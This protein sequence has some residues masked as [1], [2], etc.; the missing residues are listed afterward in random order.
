MTRALGGD[1]M[2]IVNVEHATSTPVKV[3]QTI[4]FS[5]QIIGAL[6][7]FEFPFSNE[8]LAQNTIIFVKGV[9]SDV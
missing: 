5:F 6:G 9:N 1:G 4:R 2:K 8:S 3:G 7:S